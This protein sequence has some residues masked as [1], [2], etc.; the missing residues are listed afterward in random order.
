MDFD[1][2]RRISACFSIVDFFVPI[3]VLTSVLVVFSLENVV[4]AYVGAETV[5][6]SGWILIAF[7]GLILVNLAS[8]EPEERDELEDHLEDMMD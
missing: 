1:I 2:R 6:V 8:I 7:V 4:D 3:D 5:G